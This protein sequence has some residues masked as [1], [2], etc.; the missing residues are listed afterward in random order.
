MI[1]ETRRG[2]FITSFIEKVFEKSIMEKYNNKMD[3]SIYQNG[4]QK[5]RSI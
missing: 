4:G 1:V 2:I 3:M 5:I